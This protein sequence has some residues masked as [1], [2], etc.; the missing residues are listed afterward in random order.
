MLTRR[1]FGS[2]GFVS[3]ISLDGRAKG[4][5]LRCTRRRRKTFSVVETTLP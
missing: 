2:I 4:K 5:H 3:L 1:S